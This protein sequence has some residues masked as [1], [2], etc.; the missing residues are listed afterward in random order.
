MLGYTITSLLVTTLYL[1]ASAALGDLIL[2][3]S[4][5]DPNKTLKALDVVEL[6]QQVLYIVQ[7]S[8]AD[9]LLVSDL[10][11]ISQVPGSLNDRQIY[12]LW[13]VW[14]GNYAIIAIPCMLAVG[15]FS[16]SC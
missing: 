16:K 5:V 12:R 10:S 11:S 1:V 7:I 8:L 3:E 6:A 15:S 4:A 14:G 13:V 9:S 2:I